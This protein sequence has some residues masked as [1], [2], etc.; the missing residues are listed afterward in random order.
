MRGLSICLEN[1][2][3][4]LFN[5]LSG[6]EYMH[7]DPAIIHGDLKTKNILLS[8]NGIAKIGST[9]LASES[10]FRPVYGTKK[11][12]APEAFRRVYTEKIDVFTYGHLSL[13][14]LTLW[15]IGQNGVV[16]C[17][18][19]Y[20]VVMMSFLHACVLHHFLYIYYSV[21]CKRSVQL[22]S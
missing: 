2:V 9:Q 16:L 22:I 4:I 15:C 6:L 14:T 5:V 11:D 17:M 13:V 8:K 1:Q 10:V 3:S 18:C 20:H 19:M 12:V 21:L 7:E